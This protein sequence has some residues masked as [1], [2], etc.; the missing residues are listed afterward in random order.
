[1]TVTFIILEQNRVNHRVRALSRFDGF[2][3]S[4]LAAVIY[5]VRKN[6]QRL[7]ALLFSHQ[8]VGRQ[9]NPIVE[10]GSRASWVLATASRTRAASS[11]ITIS[12]TAAAST[13]IAAVSTTAPCEL[14][15]F[16]RLEGGL[17]FW[18]RRGE[19]LQQLHFPVEMNQECKV[20][21]FP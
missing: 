14:W 10:E 17:Q 7:A 20:F 18:F 3:E 2:R 5:T 21:I 6:D 8:F 13:T 15:S 16:E 19:V 12:G 11:R 9:I 1:M 4:F